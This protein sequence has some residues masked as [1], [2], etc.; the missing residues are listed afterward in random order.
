MIAVEPALVA[1][2]VNNPDVVAAVGNRLY[3]NV[4]PEGAAFPH[5]TYYRAGTTRTRT[6]T[7]TAGTKPVVQ[8]DCWAQTYPEAKAVALAIAGAL[9]DKVINVNA[10]GIGLLRILGSWVEDEEDAYEA[11]E[12]AEEAGVHKCGLSVRFAYSGT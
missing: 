10:R 3:P 7:G 12:L 1:A 6:Y 4:A 8:F 2:L 5:V 9:N 11:P